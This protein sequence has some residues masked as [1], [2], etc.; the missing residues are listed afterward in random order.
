MRSAVNRNEALA[1]ALLGELARAGV[2]HACVCP[3]SRSAPLAIAAARTPGLRVWT[4]IDE[5]SAG[6]FALGLARA[7]R[8]P[9]ALVCT[10]GTAAANFLPAVIEASLAR[11]PL[12][13]LTADR[14]AEL[15]DWGAAQTIDQLRL[16]GSHARWFAELPAPEPTAPV[17]RSARATAARAVAV[18]QGSPPGPVQLNVPYREPLEPAPVESDRAALGALGDALALEGRA[19][20]AYTRMDHPRRAPEAARM[21]RIAA[22]IRAARRGVLLCGPCDADAGLAHALA[23]LARAAGWPLLADAASGVRRGPHAEK[24]PVLGA[25][26]SVLRAERFAE[27]HA[28]ELVLRFGPPLTSRAANLWLERHAQAEL[29][30]VD[31]DGGF[32]DPTHRAAEI[33]CDDPELLC[34]ALADEL[35]SGV[36]PGPGPWLAEFVAAEERAQR[37]LASGIARERALFAPAAVRALASALPR[38]AALFASNSM[39]IRDVDGFLEP[40]PAPLRVLANRGANGIDGIPSSA[41]GAAAGTAG[42]LACLTGDLA[43]L[44]DVGGLVAAKRHDLSALFVVLN[45][46]GGGIFSHLPVARFREDACFEELFGVPHG[47][48]LSHASAL[49]GGRHLRVSSSAELEREA[50]RSLAAGGLWVLEV[51]LEREANAAHHRAL[52]AAAAAAVDGEGPA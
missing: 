15:R 48:E 4:H 43:F 45:D 30:L 12:V 23:R 50:A 17:L 3:G 47:I 22:E 41:L 44:H 39:A 20:R 19:G 24:T 46:D 13:V 21:R 31:A 32:A 35:E 11:V 16:F 28:P 7:T 51:P 42:P 2:R 40:S 14:P 27:S 25:H 36:A 5:R 29:R 9:V 18:A 34:A 33:L 49:G 52:W 38:G 26:E 10:S 37:A 1:R 8:S 6:F